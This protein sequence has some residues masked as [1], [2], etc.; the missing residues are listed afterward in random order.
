MR[1]VSTDQPR[2]VTTWRV[3]IGATIEGVSD[4]PRFAPLFEA[5]LERDLVV[6]GVEAGVRPSDCDVSA[7]LVVRAPDGPSADRRGMEILK[8]AIEAAM[9]E[10]NHTEPVRRALQVR[11]E[12]DDSL[13]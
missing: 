8:G 12:P 3:T 5:A 13:G 7:V 1:I 2:S 10:L 9:S 4:D 11:R 6:R